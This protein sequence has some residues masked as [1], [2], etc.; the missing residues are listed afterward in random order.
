[1]LGQYSHWSVLTP[2]GGED[3]LRSA[4]SKNFRSDLLNLNCW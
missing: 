1:M 4:R 3:R 2:A